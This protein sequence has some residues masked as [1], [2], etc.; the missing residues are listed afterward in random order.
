MGSPD[1]LCEG[2]LYRVP[3]CQE[4]E[5]SDFSLGRCSCAARVVP[6]RSASTAARHGA[7]HLQH[8]LQCW[9]QLFCTR[10]AELSSFAQGT[11]VWIN[12]C[13]AS[14][15]GTLWA[16]KTRLKQRKRKKKRW[17][18]ITQYQFYFQGIINGHFWWQICPLSFIL[19]LILEEHR[20]NFCNSS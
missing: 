7:R 13:K 4:G 9:A 6:D 10:T 18:F 5:G 20:S 2:L 11:L 14:A 19:L 12:V 17:D 8:E 1:R 16:S 15:R 3:V